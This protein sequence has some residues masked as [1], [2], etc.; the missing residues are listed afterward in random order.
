[1]LNSNKF[2]ID[3]EL[4]SMLTIRDIKIRQVLLKYNRRTKEEGKKLKIND[5]WKILGKMISMIKF[6]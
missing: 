6:Y 5:G 2:E 1:M 4:S 3:V